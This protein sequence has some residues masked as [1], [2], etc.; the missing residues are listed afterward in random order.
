MDNPE[1]SAT[2]DIRHRTMTNKAKTIKHKTKKI[3][4]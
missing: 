3:Y 2:L 1:T 4:I